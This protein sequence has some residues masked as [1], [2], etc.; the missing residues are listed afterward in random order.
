MSLNSVQL[1]QA[2]TSESS[3]AV[4]TVWLDNLGVAMI[5]CC[6]AKKKK[7]SNNQNRCILGITCENPFLLRC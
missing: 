7:N 1:L 3:K 5:K 6:S 4:F 2:K